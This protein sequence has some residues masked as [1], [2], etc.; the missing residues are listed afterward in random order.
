MRKQLLGFL[1]LAACVALTAC[2][3]SQQSESQS[4]EEKQ[5]TAAEVVEAVAGQLTFVDNMTTVDGDLFF[6]FY[7]LDTEKV[8]DA[9]MYTSGS[10]ATAEE[11]TVIKMKDAADVSLAQEAVDQRVKDQRAA[12][13]NYIPEE[14][15]KLDGAVTF[16]QGQYVMLVVADDPSPA[17]QAF[18]DQF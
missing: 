5:P 16:T 11:V 4:A 10:R 15:T 12:Y 17:E 8:E 9:C 3:G 14:L 1:A 18:E 13:E 7:L 2:G 6:D